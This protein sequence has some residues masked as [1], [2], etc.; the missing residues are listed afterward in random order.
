MPD[1]ATNGRP[2]MRPVALPCS[3]LDMTT[4]LRMKAVSDAGAGQCR[5]PLAHSLSFRLR[6][7][8]A[9][10]PET[11][12]GP[13]DSDIP[14][15]TIFAPRSWPHLTATSKQPLARTRKKLSAGDPAPRGGMGRR[16]AGNARCGRALP[17]EQ[18]RGTAGNRQKNSRSPPTA[19]NAKR[20]FGTR[21]TGSAG[22]IVSRS[23][24]FHIA[25]SVVWLQLLYRTRRK[26]SLPVP[27]AGTAL[28]IPGLWRRRIAIAVIRS[29]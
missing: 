18:C 21:R 15:S 5:M 7:G 9:Q 23:C 12:A 16:V 25:A 3:A 6:E 8:S 22:K 14:L 19:G 17:R 4:V 10:R 20:F 28:K 26:C 2:L 13:A 29:S 11:S 24:W 1:I 27:E